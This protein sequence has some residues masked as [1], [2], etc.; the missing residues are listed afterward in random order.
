M[1]EDHADR[2]HCPSCGSI[3]TRTGYAGAGEGFQLA[4]QRPLAWLTI[5][6]AAMNV[7]L[8]L[9]LVS[10]YF[11]DEP[12]RNYVDLTLTR[13]YPYM[14]LAL[15][16]GG[17]SSLGYFLRGYLRKKNREHRPGLLRLSGI[18]KMVKPDTPNNTSQT[19]PSE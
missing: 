5:I 13:F 9:W 4:L 16:L 1:P 14:V 18:E 3:M 17:G 12:F 2:W 15:G 11:Y 10:N 6:L 7:V 8:S 19:T